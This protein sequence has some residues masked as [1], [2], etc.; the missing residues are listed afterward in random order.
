[1]TSTSPAPAPKLG[2][3]GLHTLSVS[4]ISVVVG[5]GQSILIARALGNPANSGPYNLA[6]ATASLAALVLGLS[7]PA[8]ATYAVARRRADPGALARW[9]LVWSVVQCAIAAIVFLVIRGSGLGDALLPVSLGL[10]AIPPVALIVAGTASANGPRGILYGKQRIITANYSDLAGGIATPFAMIV[11]VIVGVAIGS[12]Y[13]ALAF[14]WCVAFGFAVTAGRNIWMLR[15]DLR[16]LGGNPDLRVVL[17]FSLPAHAANLVQFL[18]YRLDLFLVSAFLCA[19]TLA[20]VGIYALA[21]ALAQLLWLMAQSAASV[22]APRVASELDMPGEIGI[23]SAQVARFVFYATVAGAIV[24][25]TVGRALI[26]VIY[27]DSFREAQ[28]PFLLLLPGITGFS[29]ATVL[30]AHISGSGRPFLNLIGSSV[31]LLVTLVL[32][33]MLI[34]TMG[35]PGAAIASSA[36]Y[37]TTVMVTLAIFWRMT[38]ISPLRVL[39]PTRSDLALARRLLARLAP[40]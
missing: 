38:G 33:L 35:V 13:L 37:L 7:L 3:A 19:T 27:G 34:P 20:P 26:P 36:S 18:N 2:H 25:A 23:R 32:D 12:R 24:A 4:L 10:A 22:L 6:L 8:G 15:R 17:S 31:A 16:E 29:V 28:L 30:A 1:M 21:A 14:L 39:L 5:F 40:D 9:L 11:A